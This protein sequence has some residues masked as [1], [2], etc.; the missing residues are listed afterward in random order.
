MASDGR[1]QFEKQKYLSLET[2]RKNGKGVA[3]P[4]WFAED[5]GKFYIYT[6]ADGGK[7]K[8][9]RN[10]P[11]VRVAPC[12]ARGRVTG[13]WVEGRA[14]IVGRAETE[15]GHEL[16]NRKYG[17]LKRIGDVFSKLRR[18]D[19]AVIEVQLVR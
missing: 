12:D 14:R 11:R 3:T 18:R 2:F 16:L 13:D 1:A 5:G 4:V 15:R 17:W 10:N 7:V 9:I 6:L 19:R 8:R